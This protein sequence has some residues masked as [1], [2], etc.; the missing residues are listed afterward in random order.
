[1]E[2]PLPDGR[3]LKVDVPPGVMAGNY[4]QL[5]VPKRP[6]PYLSDEEIEAAVTRK[7]NKK[8][9]RPSPATALKKICK[10]CRLRQRDRDD[11]KAAN[12]ARGK[13]PQSDEAR[14]R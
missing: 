6:N 5:K 10:S 12:I 11:K 4:F 2:V 8:R 1:M 9:K 14:D 3:T 7:I 13:V